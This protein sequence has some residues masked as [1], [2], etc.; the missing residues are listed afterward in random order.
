METVQTLEELDRL[1]DVREHAV[2]LFDAVLVLATGHLCCSRPFLLE[3][4]LHRHGDSLIANDD[5]VGKERHGPEERLKDATRNWHPA[6]VLDR[7]GNGPQS[8]IAARCGEDGVQ[9]LH[10]HL[11]V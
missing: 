6:A 7:E 9:R 11:E 4:S 3:M 8:G 1:V 2:E 5:A 10:E